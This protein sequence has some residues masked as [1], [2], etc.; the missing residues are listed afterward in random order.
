MKIMSGRLE[1]PVIER[2]EMIIVF[3]FFAAGGCVMGMVILSI[4][5]WLIRWINA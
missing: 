3:A 1:R 4:I 2:P 5:Q